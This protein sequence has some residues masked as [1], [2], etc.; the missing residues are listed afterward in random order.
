MIYTESPYRSSSLNDY[1][2]KVV[3]VIGYGGV[4]H[5]CLWLGHDRFR[6]GKCKKGYF[7][8]RSW[9]EHD[10]HCPECRWRVFVEWDGR[11]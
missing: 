9:H 7:S 3:E 1:A 5:R 2:V 6:C 8:V 11:K 4:E 10:E